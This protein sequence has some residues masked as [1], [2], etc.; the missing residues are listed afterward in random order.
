VVEEFSE[1][2]EDSII[3]QDSVQNE[4]VRTKEA[5]GTTI[6]VTIGISEDALIDSTTVTE[7]VLEVVEDLE[8]EEEQEDSIEVFH[9]ARNAIEY[10]RTVTYHQ[11]MAVVKMIEETRIAK[12]AGVRKIALGSLTWMKWKKSSRKLARKKWMICLNATKIL[13]RK[14]VGNQISSQIF[15]NH[16]K[17][18]FKFLLAP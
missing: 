17:K 18:I 2:A 15:R 14:L 8:E 5:A 11:T 7:V 6:I 12:V 10:R 3:G 1:V 16:Q 4:W 9:E 13:S